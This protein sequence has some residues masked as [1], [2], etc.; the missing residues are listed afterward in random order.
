VGIWTDDCSM[1]LCMADSLIYYKYR[2][3]PKHIR[4]LFLLWF[5]NGLDNG[6]RKHSIGLG[7]NIKISME[8]FMRK[9]D[10]YCEE[11]DRFNNGNGSLMR[12]APIPIVFRDNEEMAMKY[13]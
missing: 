3:E 12:L 2:F 10:E 1:A 6:G 11:G 13:S 8:E 4:Y 7:G 5:F 9:Q